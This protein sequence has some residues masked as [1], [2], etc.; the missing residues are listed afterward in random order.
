A[1]RYVEQIRAEGFDV[2][3]PKFLQ[4]YGSSKVYRDDGKEFVDFVY[5]ADADKRLVEDIESEYLACLCEFVESC[6]KAGIE[7]TVVIIKPPREMFSIWNNFSLRPKL[8]AALAH[9]TAYVYGSFNFRQLFPHRKQ[10]E[11]L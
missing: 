3:H 1:P 5:D 11:S 8:A 6:V 9:A 7:P 2:G 10:E 4:G